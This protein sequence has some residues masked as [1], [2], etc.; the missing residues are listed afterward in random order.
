M[1]ISNRLKKLEAS[2]KSKRLM[3]LEEM[4][5]SPLPEF[6]PEESKALRQLLRQAAQEQNH[7][8]YSATD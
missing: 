4:L 3:T 8:H 6:T 1:T 2:Q 7:A 5:N